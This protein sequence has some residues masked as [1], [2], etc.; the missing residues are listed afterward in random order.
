[1]H[2][3]SNLAFEQEFDENVNDNDYQDNPNENQNNYAY[4]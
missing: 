3:F 1:M 2:T 4:L